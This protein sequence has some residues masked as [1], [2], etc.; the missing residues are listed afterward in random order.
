MSTLI[1][2][3][4]IILGA[5]I[6]RKI[7]TLV[8]TAYLGISSLGSSDA[9][10]Q[11]APPS[12]R[13]ASVLP[14]HPPSSEADAHAW[15]GQQPRDYL[16]KKADAFLQGGRGDYVNTYRQ[17]LSRNGT[18]QQEIRS[19]QPGL[20]EQ[21]NDVFGGVPD[22]EISLVGNYRLFGACQVH[23]CGVR[24]FLVTDA[25]GDVVQ[26]A[27]LIH[28]RCTNRTGASNEPIVQSKGSTSGCENFPTLTIFYA[29][30]QTKNTAVTEQAIEWAK[31]KVA[32]F[33]NTTRLSG[34]A[35]SNLRV[36]VQF[37]HGS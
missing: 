27:G 32:N 34:K 36:E 11:V 30:P 9:A 37:V 17:S 25:G 24:A 14:T 7:T 26:A 12:N 19:T 31:S 35:S 21:F 22:P 1:R 6:M 33:A 28:Y 10:A 23:N 29:S 15:W 8:L 20:S 18:P 5:S 4:K 3:S 2:L 13:P 16:A